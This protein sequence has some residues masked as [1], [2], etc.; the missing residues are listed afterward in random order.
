MKRWLDGAIAALGVWMFVSPWVLGFSALA[1]QAAWVAWVLGAAI[2]ILGGVATY[3][4]TLG[5]EMGTLILGVLSAISPWVVAFDAE[6]RATSD[7]LT[8]GVLVVT[9]AVWSMLLD[10]KARSWLRERLHTLINP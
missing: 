1:N 4:L 10:A 3:R 8:V 7:A 2:L 6:L 9:L 5:E